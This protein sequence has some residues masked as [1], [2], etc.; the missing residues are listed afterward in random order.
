MQDEWCHWSRADHVGPHRARACVNLMLQRLKLSIP[1]WALLRFRRL[2]SPQTENLKYLA[3]HWPQSLWR[4]SGA[5]SSRTSGLLQWL[6]RRWWI[7]RRHE[8]R[9]IWNI[10]TTT[11]TISIEANMADPT[12]PT[13][14]VRQPDV[15]MSE[16]EYPT[17]GISTAW[18]TSDRKF[19]NIWP[20]AGPKA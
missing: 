10:D 7:L 3:D 1:H 19:E 13:A 17:L 4:N 20:T 5:G 2:G 15:A 6:R 18:C 9:R 16:A 8:D 12:H 14:G 11:Y